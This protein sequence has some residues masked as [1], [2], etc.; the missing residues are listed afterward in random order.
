MIDVII[1]IAASLISE[2]FFET[3][4]VKISDAANGKIKSVPLKII[5]YILIILTFVVLSIALFVL[6]ISV[7]TFIMDK[8]I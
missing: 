2:T 3:I 6:I 5:L 8:F 4:F 7:I 1:E